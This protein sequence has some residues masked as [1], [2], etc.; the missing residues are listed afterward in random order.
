MGSRFTQEIQLQLAAYVVSLRVIAR[1]GKHS[2][3]I[4]LDIVL[5]HSSS[6]HQRK[7]DKGIY[8]RLLNRVWLAL[9][10]AASS[11][12][13]LA[14]TFPDKVKLNDSR[15]QSLKL[16]MTIKQV[17][18]LIGGELSLKPFGNPL[19]AY[20]ALVPDPNP[21]YSG[22]EYSYLDFDPQ[23]RLVRVSARL[24]S[25]IKR[26][27]AYALLNRLGEIKPVLPDD[28]MYLNQGKTQFTVCVG[29]HQSMSLTYPPDDGVGLVMWTIQQYIRPNYPNSA[30]SM[31]CKSKASML[32]KKV[33][34]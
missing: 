1:H 9:A 21:L 29:H 34:E 26:E 3:G 10:I 13:T 2:W 18:K 31:P 7:N 22:W 27:N 20:L 19:R 8:M 23:R 17:E 14:I 4:F 12:S 33:P 6:L 25:Q 24:A 5:L 30:T 32:K 11:S 16:G 28:P 15:L